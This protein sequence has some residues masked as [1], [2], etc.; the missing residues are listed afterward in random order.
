MTND[1]KRTV[2][3]LVDIKGKQYR[4]ESDAVLTVDKLD[5]A[6]GATLN[7]DSVVLLRD[8]ATV[9]VGTPYVAGAGVSAV[10]ESHGRAPKVTVF[11]HKRRKN[12]RRTKGHRAHYSVIKVTAV[13]GGG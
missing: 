3:A 6:P 11:K 8:D 1:E 9:R 4:A 10:V 13:S 12:Y 5:E 7:F 2:Y